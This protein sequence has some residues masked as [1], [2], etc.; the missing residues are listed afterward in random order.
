M[1]SPLLMS[2]AKPRIRPQPEPGSQ[3]LSITALDRAASDVYLQHKHRAP[4]RV[5]RRGLPVEYPGGR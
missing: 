1:A 4:C 2:A 3:A 5:S